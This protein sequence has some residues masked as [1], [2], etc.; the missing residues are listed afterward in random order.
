MAA[1]PDRLT[2]LDEPVERDRPALLGERNRSRQRV[3]AP[4]LHP[5]ENAGSVDETALLV[6]GVP[7]EQEPRLLIGR[8]EPLT[9]ELAAGGSNV[10]EQP[11]ENTPSQGAIGQIPFAVR[12]L[13]PR[14][15]DDV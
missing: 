15:T 1:L 5:A 6:D 2:V 12:G 7:P 13:T 4:P 9:G 10:L 8:D 14:R 3:L 11:S